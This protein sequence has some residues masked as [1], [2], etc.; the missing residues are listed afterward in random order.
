MKNSITVNFMPM[1][2]GIV[3]LF[4]GFFF[5]LGFGAA[6]VFSQIGKQETAFGEQGTIFIAPNTITDNDP[7]SFKRLISLG[8]GTKN[9]YDRRT[10]AWSDIDVHIFTAEFNDTSNKIEVRVNGEFDA[11]TA[12]KEADK[13]LR[14]VGQLPFVLKEKLKTV[15]I[16]K[17]NSDYGGGGF[18]LLIHT[19]RTAEYVEKGILTETLIHE[20]VHAVFDDAYA[21]DEKW[22]AA[23]KKDSV[24]ISD[25][26]RDN[27][28]R[29]DLA[30][31]F[32][33]FLMVKYRPDRIDKKMKDLI[34]RTIPNRIAF[35]D[36]LNLDMQPFNKPVLSVSQ[37]N[38]C[39]N[40]LTLRS[41]ESVVKSLFTLT[42]QSKSSIVLYW[43]NFEG[44]RVKHADIEPNAQVE[45]KTFLTHPWVV[46]DS[47]GKCLRI[48]E[49][50]GDIIIK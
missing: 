24:F 34:E 10:D 31:S 14:A 5:V 47:N 22:K 17:G 15:S 33:P 28:D 7:T 1:N 40:E 16:H 46:T 26:A 30:E 38:S 4:I 19:G 36:S 9:L 11:K 6:N 18:D 29:E 12:S 44:E 32:L 41:K 8:T 45:H 49:A 50:P 20:T 48:F 3:G 13:H 25:Y 39:G 21:N 27:P 35:L 2:I 23:Q 42:N 43:I 37:T